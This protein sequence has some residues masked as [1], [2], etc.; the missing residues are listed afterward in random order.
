[1]EFK[2]FELNRDLKRENSFSMNFFVIQA[3]RI[4]LVRLD[5][6]IKNIKLSVR[7]VVTKYSIKKS[8]KL[9]YFPTNHKMYSG[10]SPDSKMYF[11]V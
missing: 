6:A 8:K 9:V 5:M 7:T 4:S 11:D 10:C 1:M 3:H 2:A